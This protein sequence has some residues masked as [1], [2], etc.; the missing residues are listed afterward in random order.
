[1][2]SSSSSQQGV[3][4]LCHQPHEKEDQRSD[5]QPSANDREGW[6]QYWTNKGQPWRTEPEISACRQYALSQRRL[7]QPEPKKGIYPFGGVSLDRADIEWL[8]ASHDNGQGPVEWSDEQQQRRNGLDLRGACVIEGADLDKL[9]LT[10]L[11]GGLTFEERF[12]LHT[13]PPFLCLRRVALIG[14]RLQEA[15]LRY[16]HLQEAIL[17]YAYL[18]RADLWEA[19]LE[20]VVLIG[21]YLQ[22]ADLRRTY[23]QGADLRGAS[24][25]GADLRGAS[26]SQINLFDTVLVDENGVGPS[27]ADVQWGET[28]LS[29][30]DWSQIR[31]LGDEQRASQPTADGKK[32]D[33]ATRQKEYQAAYRANHQLA[34]AL[35]NQ[36]LVED[37]S[38]FT[39]RAKNLER[40]VRSYELKN[41]SWRDKNTKKRT[42][43]SIGK[44]LL[45]F[46]PALLSWLFSWFLFLIAGYGYRLYNCVFWY[47]VVVGGCAFAYLLMEPHYF[48]WWTALAESVN[49]FHGRGASPSLPQLAHPARFAVLTI[50]EA[51]TGLVIEVILVATLIQRFFGK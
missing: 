36:G 34:I 29:L 11:R 49:V 15:V 21:A 48:T 19:H 22:G 31:I 17:R 18:E 30:A 12:A 25:Q 26:C 27:L 42:V 5:Q 3:C 16:A 33:R 6:K 44:G 24:L 43:N 9:P 32:K 35:Q 46:L 4:P 20:G 10:R 50:A 28:N 23:L 40:V 13:A 7:I 38:R 8:L 37:A 45:H 47:I 39:Y 41:I 2:R 14:V 1:M 51:W